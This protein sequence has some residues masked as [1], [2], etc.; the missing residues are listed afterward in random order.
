MADNKRFVDKAVC[1]LFA[2]CLQI[3][4]KNVK[5]NDNGY[6]PHHTY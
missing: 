4:C 6:S 5:Y 2:G 1:R 3:V